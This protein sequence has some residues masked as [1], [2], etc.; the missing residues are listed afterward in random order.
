MS[1]SVSTNSAQFTGR[2]NDLT[3]LYY[4]RARYYYP[5]GGRFVSEDPLGHA[6][7]PN[8]F[9]YVNNQPTLFTDP[10]GLKP[11]P[12]FG[13]GMLFAGMGGGGAGGVGGGGGGGGG[14]ASGKGAGGDQWFGHDDRDFQ[15][16]FHRHWKRE[17][18]PDATKKDLDDA[19]DEWDRQGRPKRD[20]KADWDR[21]KRQLMEWVKTHQTEIMVTTAVTV[22]V[23]GVTILSGGAGGLGLGLAF[24]F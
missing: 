7:G 16:W 10:N 22:T 12:D 5:Q 23:A 3:G 17:G 19:Y 20:P 9:A 13:D 24:A 14:R 18:D 1:A 11:K 6:A 4:Y 2:D 8:L 21:G 15:D